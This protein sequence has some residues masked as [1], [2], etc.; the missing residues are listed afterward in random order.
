MTHETVANTIRGRFKTLIADTNSLSTQYDNQDFTKPADGSMWCR[1]TI[2]EGDS[3]QVSIGSTGSRTERTSGIV[4]AQVFTP[5]GIGDKA[6]IVMADKIKVAFRRITVNGVRF[7]TPS[8]K[9]I[10]R[11]DSEWQINVVCPFKFDEIN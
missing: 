7:L 1:L 5:I 3:E 9:R 8:I 4:I 11:V 2:K 10:G 6:G